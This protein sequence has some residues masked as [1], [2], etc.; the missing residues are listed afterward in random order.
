M[1][2]RIV[3]ESVNGQAIDYT[4]NAE[5]ERVSMTA[6]GEQ[7]QYGRDARGLI[8]SISAP[9]GDYALAHDALSRRTQL[10]TPHGQTVDYEYGPG[11]R[12]T[13]ITYM[14]PYS[15]S[16]SYSYNA[17]GLIQQ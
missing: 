12:P 14:G 1:D 2:S 7:I 6:L 5:G 16:L 3:S 17:R 13:V 4:Y 11:N 10:T 9:E 8:D 15:Q